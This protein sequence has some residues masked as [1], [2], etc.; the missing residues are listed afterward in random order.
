MIRR[1]WLSTVGAIFYLHIGRAQLDQTRFTFYVTTLGHL[2]RSR[3]F[4]TTSRWPRAAAIHG[5]KFSP[6]FHLISS[7]FL[8]TLSPDRTHTQIYT[9]THN[10][11]WIDIKIYIYIYKYI[12]K[13]I[14]ITRNCF[15]K[16]SF[17]QTKRKEKEI[18]K[19]AWKIRIPSTM[20]I[21]NM[22]RWNS[23]GE[24]RTMTDVLCT[25]ITTS[26]RDS[27][28]RGDLVSR[29]WSFSLSL[30]R[31][32]SPPTAIPSLPSHPQCCFSMG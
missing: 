7:N 14:Y 31:R 9:Y 30:R 2:E 15:I 20:I 1:S 13:Y 4:L 25:W 10:F 23:I 17:H 21:E 22:S 18:G 16:L 12:Y 24:A 27:A 6:I 3:V 5:R 26:A 29:V 28:A 19:M 8:K 11:L 32:V